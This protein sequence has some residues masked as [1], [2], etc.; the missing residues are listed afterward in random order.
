MENIPARL[1]CAY[2]IRNESHGGECRRQKY[3][4][5]GCLAFKLDPKGCIRNGNFKIEIPLYYK[6]PPLRA[7]C[8]DWQIN[9][10][11]TQI[12]INWINGL[13][14]DTK[15][16]YLIIY[17]DLDYYINEYHEDYVEPEKKPKLKIIK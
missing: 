17:C 11:D 15:K 6:F 4:D 8:D 2:C 3:D 14:W 13:D 10:V 16:G 9:G 1:Q 7:W 5:I 12:R